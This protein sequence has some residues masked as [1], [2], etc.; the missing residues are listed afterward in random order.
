MAL[1]IGL[2]AAA[3]LCGCSSNGSGATAETSSV[4]TR[5]TSSRPL[6]VDSSTPDVPRFVDTSIAVGQAPSELASGFGSV[7][8]VT[9]RGGEV[10]RIDTA[11]RHL[12]ARVRSRG[13]EL[14]G[15]AVGA[16]H[17]WYLDADLQQVEGINARTNR[18]D[19]QIPVAS[20]GGSLAYGAGALWF[21]GTSGKLLRIDP[22]SGHVTG[23]R[24]LGASDAFLSVA[25]DGTSIWASD[26]DR[27]LIFRIDPHT[28]RVTE[29]KKVSGT[30]VAL[31][32]AFASL[33][34]GSDDGHLFRLEPK[35][36]SIQKTIKLPAVDHLGAGAH[37]LWVR[38][39]DTSLVGVD[40][41]TGQV[42]GRY[43]L[44]FAEIP[45]GGIVCA[46]GAVWAV[47]WTKDTVWRIPTNT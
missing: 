14:I 42:Q 2:A 37:R 27:S 35:S 41:S 7:W 23:S 3:L 11:S 31:A 12:A 1:S 47:N 26:G 45:G 18:I 17:V 13:T 19:L 34:A 25:S 29:T 21:A 40:P 33:F 36:L 30:I 4:A 39:S 15:I 9:H 20:D 6:P 43:A 22:T 28:A 5:S 38:V 10:D 46:G 32:P 44:P 24:R 8:V 16:G